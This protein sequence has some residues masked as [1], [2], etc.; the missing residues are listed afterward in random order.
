MIRLKARIVIKGYQHI[1]GADYGETYALV[2]KLVSFQLLLAMAA[3]Y[4]WLIHH[5]D[6]VTA[7]LN[8]W[9]EDDI[10]MEVPEGIECPEP[11]WS[12]ENRLICKLKKYLYGLKQA[13]RL[14]YIH[15]VT[16]FRL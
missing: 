16:F 3:R 12:A 1:E 13:L 8:P 11:S 2:A 4:S 5:M 14:W 15:I 9:V 10:Y 6:M 7:F